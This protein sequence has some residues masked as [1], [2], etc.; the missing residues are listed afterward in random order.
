MWS[1]VAGS[2]VGPASAV[3]LTLIPGV[4]LVL[5][6]TGLQASFL[7]A[8][9]PV[10]IAVL[11]LVRRPAGSRT[12]AALLFAGVAVR[13]ATIPGGTS[14][15]LAVTAAADARLL[16]GLDP[17][18]V[19]YAASWPPGA[20]FPYGPVALLWYLPFGPDLRQVEMI[21][22]LLVLGLLAARGRP[23]GLAVYALAP[24]L[25][26]A[27]S[28][29]SNDTSAGLLL[30]A[31]L[32]AAK[33]SPVAG[34][35]GLAVAA[36]FKPYA[37]AWVPA[38]GIWG[39]AGALAAGAAASALLWGP[40]LLV[41]GVGPVL[42]SLRMATAVH[43]EP[44]LTVAR[45]VEQLL[46]AR[47]SRLAFDALALAAGA[48]AALGTLPLARTWGGFL[49][50]GVAVFGI[51]LYCGYWASVTYL[52]AIAPIL[53]WELDELAGLA[54]RRVRWPGDPIGRLESAL[55]QRRPLAA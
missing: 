43:A 6:A 26:I 32:L 40:A 16:S 15:V 1:L 13:M 51:T 36:A 48:L 5:P 17:W 28:D 53:C 33:R 52:A 2:R 11:L 14:D 47:V 39:G 19:G 8:G 23:L 4:L 21:A 31:A 30:L 34:A 25:I 9:F 29:G 41:S 3:W 12:V 55:E 24:V 38:L 22:S 7:L 18:G 35:V 20:P 10:A 45:V 37:L 50:A 27:A 42:D 49:G 44:S 54:W 46:H